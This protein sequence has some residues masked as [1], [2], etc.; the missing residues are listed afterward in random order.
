MERSLPGVT[1]SGL[2]H[3]ERTR[4]LTACALTVWIRIQSLP[5]LRVSRTA[6]R[7]VFVGHLLMTVEVDQIEIPLFHRRI[8][9]A[10]VDDITVVATPPSS[11]PAPAGTTRILLPSFSTKA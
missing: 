7:A 6:I 11:H 5:D 3:G 9:G 2:E 8:L 10:R 1:D 4:A